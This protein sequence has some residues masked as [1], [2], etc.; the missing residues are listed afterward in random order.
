VGPS[1]RRGARAERPLRQRTHLSRRLWLVRLVMVVFSAV[2]VSVG[3]EWAR[4]GV[5]Q[6]LRAQSEAAVSS[7]IAG[8]RAALASEQ[9][10]AAA[11]VR[12]AVAVVDPDGRGFVL[13]PEVARVLESYARTVGDLGGI[14]I[15]GSGGEALWQRGAPLH[16]PS[17]VDYIGGLEVG[18]MVPGGRSLVEEVGVEA[19]GP[20]KTTAGEIVALVRLAVPKVAGRL[21]LTSTDSRPIE[22]VGGRAYAL[23]GLP[24]GPIEGIS[25]LVGLQGA[26]GALGGSPSQTRRA[27]VTVVVGAVVVFV[28]MVVGG[29]LLTQLVAYGEER[30][31]HARVEAEAARLEQG[32]A[33]AA[34]GAHS[35]ER[36]GDA[37]AMLLGERF[38]G[39]ESA[40]ILVRGEPVVA[41][42]EGAAELLARVEGLAPGELRAERE[43]RAHVLMRRGRGG[44]LLAARAVPGDPICPLAVL[45]VIDLTVLAVGL[46]QV[47]ASGD[48]LRMA[49]AL[50][51][52]GTPVFV[53]E[54]SGVL[55]WANQSLEAQFGWRPGM[56]LESLIGEGWRGIDPEQERVLSG[57]DG[58]MRWVRVSISEVFGDGSGAVVGI[59]EDRT[60]TRLEN[61]RL[62]HRSTHD[63]LT[64]AL[65]RV[66]LEAVVTA[67]I[68][69]GGPRGR[70]WLGVLDLDGFK[71][72]NDTFGHAIGDEVLRAVA[73]RL[74]AALE[75]VGELARFGGDEFVLVVWDGAPAQSL[76]MALAVVFDEP[77]VLGE[78]F[79]VRLGGSL[80]IARWP[81]HGATFDQL[82]READR[83]LYWAKGAKG[84][85]G[86]WW[87][88][89]DEVTGSQA[90]FEDAF[91]PGGR[92]W[93]EAGARLV[94][95]TCEALGGR[96]RGTHGMA[97]G[98][99]DPE[100]RDGL[101]CQLGL[102]AESLVPD[103]QPD[104]LADRAR[105]VG[106]RLALAGATAS[107]LETL[108]ATV[109]ELMRAQAPPSVLIEHLVAISRVRLQGVVNAELAAMVELRWQYLSTMLELPRPDDKAPAIWGRELLETLA[110]LPGIQFGIF[111]ATEGGP[112]RPFVDAVGRDEEALAAWLATVETAGLLD[113]AQEVG[114]G[115][116]RRA[117]REG[118]VVCVEDLGAEERYGEY[119]ALSARLGVRSLAICPVILEERPVGLVVLGGELSGMFATPMVRQLLDALVPSLARGFGEIAARLQ[120]ARVGAGERARLA[121]HEGDILSFA[122]PIVGLADGRVRQVELLARMR[123][124]D[125]RVMAPAEFL[126]ALGP[127][128][129]AAVFLAHLERVPALLARWRTIVP[130]LRVAVNVGATTLADPAVAE[131]LRAL[132]REDGLKWLVLEVLESDSG[133]LAGVVE[134]FLALG[135][136]LAI[137]DLGSGFSNLERLVDLPLWEVKIDRSLVSRLR[138]APTISTAVLAGLVQGAHDMERL[139][140]FEGVEDADLVE[141]ARVLDAD[142]VQG[143]H[144]GRPMAAEEL[145][146]WLRRRKQTR[147]SDALTTWVGAIAACWRESVVGPGGPGDDGHGCALGEFLARQEGAG[148]L[149]RLH[150]GFHRQGRVRAQTFR[151][152]LAGLEARLE[153]QA[154]SQPLGAAEE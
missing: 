50:E 118:Q 120:G 82:V 71:P 149:A 22:L 5:A 63:A 54:G 9:A 45:G 80:G 49:H 133:R 99:L 132:G 44:E 10:E 124:A 86:R 28:L 7:E 154:A 31:V 78:G 89:C 6:G 11:G 128:E 125:G 77:I 76:P 39:L 103:A 3:A 33:E 134:E 15:L 81:E 58:S 60:L 1:R 138:T 72:I 61:E 135:A 52:L 64:G 146:P 108:V 13:G 137:D 101:S 145:E 116:G 150:L 68:E 16:P 2:V 130:D 141:A 74:E 110:F 37:V 115:D 140:V 97:E 23:R 123:G 96:L 67:E 57:R 126:D 151:D 83:A 107:D 91:G 24:R 100:G 102:I 35:R 84:G 152:L 75:G 153:A 46:E 148:M 105:E 112:W 25:P 113:P 40:T 14:S 38:P 27:L 8:A 48:R 73:A 65:N 41:L 79:E 139:V 95:S 29:L 143:Y 56:T 26:V 59:L 70:F 21:V 55:S 129:L 51:S 117:W 111:I 20:A 19:P 87:L 93:L 43:G 142:L 92:R 114:P 144:F 17:P 119:R 122:Q 53:A 62:T 131:R 136:G 106:R 36:Y 34:W 121:V 47:I 69:A 90:G 18:P 85:R 88:F 104:A 98:A 66:A 109:L 4:A 94:A 32:I 30:R 12:F 42:G 147:P 127:R